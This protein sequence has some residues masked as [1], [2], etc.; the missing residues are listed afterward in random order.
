M[1]PRNIL[2]GSFARS[3]PRQFVL[4]FILFTAP[5]VLLFTLSEPFAEPRVGKVGA[6]KMEK[7]QRA[8]GTADT[9]TLSWLALQPWQ[10]TRCTLSL[11]ADPGH[12]AGTQQ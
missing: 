9:F 1:S 5:I 6:H 11:V 4:F 10:W 8:L 12:S 7:T 2:L 3:G